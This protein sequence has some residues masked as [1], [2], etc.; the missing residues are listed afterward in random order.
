MNR[1]LLILPFFA[2]AMISWSKPEKAAASP[3]NLTERVDGGDTLVL[4]DLIFS[5]FLSPNGDGLNDRFIIVNVMYYP[6]NSIKIFNR[7]GEMVYYAAPYNNEWDGSNNRGNAM[8]NNNLTDGTYYFE[9]Y[10]GIGNNATG[11]ITLKR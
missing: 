4:N 1:I 5:D 8:V 3:V 7:W 11:K 2:L 10:D 9:F 6:G